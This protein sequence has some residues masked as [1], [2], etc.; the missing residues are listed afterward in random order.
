MKINQRHDRILR[1]LAQKGG[2]SVEEIA[3][4]ST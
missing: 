2:L 4:S 3:T 1:L